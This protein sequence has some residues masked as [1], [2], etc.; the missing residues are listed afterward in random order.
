[1]WLVILNTRNTKFKPA[2]MP[3]FASLSN[4]SPHLW[5]PL[6][7]I[8]ASNHITL[9]QLVYSGTVKHF[10]IHGS[11]VPSLHGYEASSV[12]TY[13]M[14]YSSWKLNAGL[15]RFLMHYM[16]KYTFA[17]LIAIHMEALKN[18]KKRRIKLQS[19]WLAKCLSIVSAVVSRDDHQRWLKAL[20]MP[21]SLQSSS[22][23]N[24]AGLHCFILMM[25]AETVE[26]FIY[27]YF[28]GTSP[29]ITTEVWLYTSNW[30]FYLYIPK[31][32]EV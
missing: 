23:W 9:K 24:S 1:M 26:N 31:C 19:Y 11:F 22:V 13:T 6:Y 4:S 5:S 7:D 2:N 15:R 28:Y 18:T 8:L 21:N 12:L 30:G 16:Y 10:L 3:S 14:Y 29:V 32:Y 25:T 20:D 27:A 17:S